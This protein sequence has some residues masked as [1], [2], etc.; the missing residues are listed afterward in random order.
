M[1]VHIQFDQP[2][3]R[4][5]TNLD[6]ISGRVILVLPSDASISA[7]TVKLEGESRV[8]LAVPKFPG[9]ERSDKKRTELEV[10]K[11]GEHNSMATC[12]NADTR[13]QL[14]YKVLTLFPTAELQE[15][16]SGNP[17]TLLAGQYTYP[18]SFKVGTNG[19]SKL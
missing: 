10:H 13:Q 12:N 3:A 2:P 17:F 5:Y 1:S 7:V 8:R 4:C 18:F 15:T 19:H 6:F 11:V 9:N 14:L 16:G